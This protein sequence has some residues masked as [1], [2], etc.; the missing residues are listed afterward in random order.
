MQFGFVELESARAA[1]SKVAVARRAAVLA[2]VLERL[3]HGEPRQVAHLGD[4]EAF[5]K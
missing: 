5:T 3:G 2:A 1:V 4:T